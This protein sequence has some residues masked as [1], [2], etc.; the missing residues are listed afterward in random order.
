MKPTN[1]FISY[2]HKDADI[3]D[4]VH[5]HLECL[6]K[7]NLVKIYYDEH[8]LGGDEIDPTIKA[9][10]DN[11]SLALFM[12][13]ANFIDSKYCWKIER[14]L[15]LERKK[16]GRMHVVGVLIEDCQWHL[17]ELGLKQFK[18]L[19][20]DAKAITGRDWHNQSEALS[21][22]ADG[23][24]KVCR[25]LDNK[26]EDTKE[27]VNEFDQCQSDDNPSPFQKCI[28]QFLLESAERK[29][30][31]GALKDKF[32]DIKSMAFE[33][34]N[35]ALLSLS[36]DLKQR[37]EIHTANPL[38]TLYKNIYYTLGEQLID[39]VE[40]RVIPSTVRVLNNNSTLLETAFLY[41]RNE[42]I[43]RFCCNKLQRDILEQSLDLLIKRIT[44]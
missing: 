27:F 26:L 5:T 36:A 40:Y 1:V 32:P 8:M 24:L 21:D 29:I 13:S 11:S 15:I 17:P 10:I 22:M 42:K 4:K 38:D 20:K 37:E 14:E 3:C 6:V 33:A 18:M 31:A 2:S 43:T 25:Q 44:S 34:A 19:P 23:I 30:L 9:Y 41:I 12:I 7:A 39:I 35:Y 16:Q 28:D